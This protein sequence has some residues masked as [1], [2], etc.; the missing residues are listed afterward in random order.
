MGIKDLTTIL[1]KKNQKGTLG[2]YKY[3]C[4]FLQKKMMIFSRLSKGSIIQ[5]LETNWEETMKGKR[6]KKRKRDRD[7]EKEREG[8][9]RRESER[10]RQRQRQ[11]ECY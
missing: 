5:K 1:K 9:E 10:H 6:E 2:A 4:I 8:E 7:R 11:Y 3:I